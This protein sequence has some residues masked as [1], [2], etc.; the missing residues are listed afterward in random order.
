[1]FTSQATHVAVEPVPDTFFPAAVQL[2]ASEAPVPVQVKP[3]E[4]AQVP[5]PAADVE[6]VWH[7][8]H[9][10]LPVVEHAVEV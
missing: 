2:H 5:A 10:A 4:A 8:V 9:A 6:P 7:A 1:V 3:A